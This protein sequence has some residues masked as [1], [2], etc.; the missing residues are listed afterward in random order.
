MLSIC[1]KLLGE[2]RN[3]ANHCWQD[4]FAKACTKSSP[5]KLIHLKKLYH[6][7]QYYVVILVI[8]YMCYLMWSEWRI[9]CLTDDNIEILNQIWLD[10]TAAT[11]VIIHL[12]HNSTH[13]NFRFQGG[14][15]FVQHLQWI[16]TYFLIDWQEVT[17]IQISFLRSM[18]ETGVPSQTAT[19]ATFL[20]LMFAKL[21][22]FTANYL[23]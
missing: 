10:P 23:L 22:V 17:S 19:D 20:A 2:N 4:K 3:V 6:C 16:S 1:C 18:L 11:V 12:Q 13:H 14:V 8:L 21:L 9:R 15:D 7:K 5:N